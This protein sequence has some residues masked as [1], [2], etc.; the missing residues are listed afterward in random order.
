M[1]SPS[2]VLRACLSRTDQWAYKIPYAIQWVWPLPI[3]VACFFAPESP[4]WLVRHNKKE[5]AEKVLRRL[6]S[7]SSGLSSERAASKINEMSLT[8]QLE[9]QTEH[10]ARYID[11]FKGTNRRRTEI[12]CMVYL[13]QTICGAPLM[14]Y[15]SYFMIQAGMSTEN[16]FSMS[17]GLFAIGFVG[18]V[19]SWFIMQKVNRRTLFLTGE[20]LL[21]VILV[22]IGSIAA[23]IGEKP[24]SGW[25]IA[26]FLLIFTFVYDCTIG[27]VCYAL[28]AEVPASQVRSKTVAL[29]RN[30]YNLLQIVTMVIQPRMLNT[31]SNIYIG[32]KSAFVWAV[33]AALFTIWTYFRLPDP[34]GRTYLELDA[35][36]EA[37]VPARKFRTT[38]LELFS[39][40]QEAQLAEHQKGADAKTAGQKAAPGS[41][42]PKTLPYKEA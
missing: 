22:I 18:T 1:P 34:T 11:C 8:V 20:M 7:K 3:F 30:A 40:A 6:S 33:P 36:F 19:S 14:G 5:E 17:T 35:L 2:G 28:V 21:V 4:W 38:R 10:G 13:I 42:A 12:G 27:P 25:A 9:K 26:A 29:S 37:K 16:A 39:H 23:A 31:T 32:A 15:A 24:S 41:E